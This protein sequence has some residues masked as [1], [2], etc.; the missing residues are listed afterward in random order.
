MEH[1][2]ASEL[3]GAARYRLLIDTICPRPIAW[4]GTVDLEGNRNLAPFSFFNGVS[5]RPPIISIAIAAKVERHADGSRTSRD[6]DTLANMRATQHFV[7]HPAPDSLWREVHASGAALPPTVDEAEH[8][9]LEWSEGTW[10]PAPRLAAA[11]VALEC[12]VHKLI[13][14]GVSPSTTLVLGEVLGWHL[15]EG[16]RDESGRISATGWGPLGRLGV[17]GYSQMGPLLDPS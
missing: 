7:V 6:K 16:L 17:D 12:K 14:V 3:R 2:S 8:C 1:L 15:A 5:S 11:P 13:E 4:V 9:G 10:G